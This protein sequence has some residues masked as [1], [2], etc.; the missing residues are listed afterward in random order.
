MNVLI[1][2]TGIT[3]NK[4][5]VGV[6]AKNLIHELANHHPELHLFLVVQDDDSDLDYSDHLNVTMIW[7]PAKFFRRLFLRFLLEQVG[8]PMLS[9]KYRIKVIH[10]LHYSFPIIRF[11][12]RQVVTLH[13]MTSYNMP[14]VHIPAKRVYFR[15][16]IRIAKYFADH[17][18]FVSASAQHDFTVRFGAPRGST[19]VVLH[20]KSEAFR[21]DLDI[22]AIQRTREKYDLPSSFILYIGTIEPRKNLSRLVKAFASLTKTYPEL[23][24]VIAGM[25]GWMYDQLF[26][27]IRQLGL[28]SRIA[29]PGFIAEEDK[30]LLLSAATIF[31]YP[32]MYEGFGLPVLEALACGIPTVTSNTSSIPEVVGDAALLINPMNEIEIARAI[33]MLLSDSKLREDLSR[34]SILQAARFTWQKTAD[35]TVEGYKRA[36]E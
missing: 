12:T 21:P 18:I 28:P 35:L 26:E 10:S 2:A 36:M 31:V 8:L 1:D 20:G 22:Q 17:L 19:S 7:V 34:R 25:K 4:A 33:E 9:L 5:G 24:L 13:D 29:F 16:F 14:E 30:A 11:G 27:D 3:K 6:Y 15:T 23:I 32:S